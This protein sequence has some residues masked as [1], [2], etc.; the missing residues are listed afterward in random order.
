MGD[1]SQG[2]GEWPNQGP[3][4]LPDIDQKTG[5]QT[6]E[7]GSG[8]RCNSPKWQSHQEEGT[9]EAQEKPR[10]GALPPS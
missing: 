6:S 9:E 8:D 3:V 4:G 10:A 1:T 2:G 7:E 5:G